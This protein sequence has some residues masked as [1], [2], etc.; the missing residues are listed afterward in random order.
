MWPD[1]SDS[2][3]NR[4]PIRPWYRVYMFG[5]LYSRLVRRT[6]QLRHSNMENRASSPDSLEMDKL[7]ARIGGLRMGVI[8]VYRPRRGGGS[9]TSI[10]FKIG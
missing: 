7:G 8:A 6:G 4:Q 3:A 10:L 5:G 9:M 2:P 1:T